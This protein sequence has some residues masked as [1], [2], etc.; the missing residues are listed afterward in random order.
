MSWQEVKRLPLALKQQHEFLMQ[1]TEAC[2]E[3]WVAKNPAENSK[4]KYTDSR[5]EL[6]AFKRKYREEGYYL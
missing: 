4:E 3:N 5:A 6:L 1:Q 2:Y